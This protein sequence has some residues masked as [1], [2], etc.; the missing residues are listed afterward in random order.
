[1]RHPSLPIFAIAQYRRISVRMAPDF[2]DGCLPVR[3]WL[4]AVL[5]ATFADWA[6]AHDLVL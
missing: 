4:D 6:A 3:R 2:F 5:Q 1:M